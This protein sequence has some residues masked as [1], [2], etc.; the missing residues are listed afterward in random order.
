MDAVVVITAWILNPRARRRRQQTAE[1]EYG[2]Q[3]PTINLNIDNPSSETITRT[4]AEATLPL[5]TV[6]ATPRLSVDQGPTSTLKDLA[7][8]DVVS[9]YV[10]NSRLLLLYLPEINEDAPNERISGN[11]TCLPN[12]FIKSC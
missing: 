2:S 4:D 9:L 11:I 1:S 10:L 12:S 5:Q 3:E 6:N 8:D 7:K